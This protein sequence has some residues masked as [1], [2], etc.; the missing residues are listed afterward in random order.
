MLGLFVAC[1]REENEHVKA[2]SEDLNIDGS[3]NIYTVENV[4]GASWTV[5]EAPEWASSSCV[6]LPGEIDGKIALRW[7]DGY[8]SILLNKHTAGEM[9]EWPKAVVC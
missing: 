9:A 7:K 1:S 6:K 4:E 2:A 5:V 3:C 8:G